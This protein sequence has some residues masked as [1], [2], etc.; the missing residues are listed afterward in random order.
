VTR[1]NSEG[2]TGRAI[3]RKGP[4]DCDM[5]KRVTLHW[6][7]DLEFEVLNPEGSSIPFEAGPSAK[8]FRPSALIPAGLAGCI[9]LDVFE[10][11]QKKRQ[12]VDAYEVQVVGQQREEHPRYFTSIDVLHLINGAAIDDAA[13]N[14]AIALSARKYCAVGATLA[15]GDTTIKHRMRIVDAQGERESDCVTVGPHGAGLASETEP[16]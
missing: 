3:A 16:A 8:T 2:H 12:A 9:G 6:K 15:M 13:A 14:R 11:L 5:E 4:Y 10:I 1:P 7:H